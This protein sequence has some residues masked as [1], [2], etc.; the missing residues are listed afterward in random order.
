MADLQKIAESVASGLLTGGASVITTV[1]AVFQ[2]I[3]KRVTNLE[4]KLGTAEP[5]TGVYLALSLIEESTKKLRKE[6]EG[7]EDD[8]PS[9]AKR[10]LS[11]ARSSSSNDL[12]GQLDFENRI[13]R[14]LKEFRDRLKRLEDHLEER[15]DQIERDVDRRTLAVEPGEDFIAREEYVKDSQHRAEEMIKTREQL[16]G[17]NGL[18]RGVMAALGYIDDKSKYPGRGERDG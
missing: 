5:K 8:P 16:A 1:F 9:W 17:V 13:D 7:W 3:K 11:R 12:S 2:D 6:I 14:S 4:E 15:V 10:L 18:L